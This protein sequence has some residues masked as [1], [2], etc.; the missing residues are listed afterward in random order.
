M[1]AIV[2]LILLTLMVGFQYGAQAQGVKLYKQDKIRTLDDRKDYF[3]VS[4]IIDADKCC[5]SSRF[6]GKIVGVSVD[7]IQVS[8]RQLETR[9]KEDDNGFYSKLSFNT[10]KELPIYSLAK[11]S[12]TSFEKKPNKLK[13][14]LVVVGGILIFTSVA[15]AIHAFVVDGDDRNALLISSGIQVGASLAFLI[16]AAENPKYKIGDGAWNF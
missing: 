15:T 13:E 1:R 6:L 4:N 7:S 3:V 8:A 14:T 2:R 11:N 16:T 10:K 5:N 12:I 9:R